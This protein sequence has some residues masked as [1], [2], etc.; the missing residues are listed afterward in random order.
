MEWGNVL[1]NVLYAFLVIRNRM[2]YRK[3]RLIGKRKTCFAEYV[4]KN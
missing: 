3:I 1:G 4:D 2:V